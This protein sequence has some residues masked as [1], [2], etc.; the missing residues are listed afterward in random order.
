MVIG[1]ADSECTAYPLGTASCSWEKDEQALA[2]DTLL[3]SLKGM[4]AYAFPPR[5]L[6]TEVLK[7]IHRDQCKVI[8]I[9][10]AWPW[11][12]WFSMILDLLI[13]L[14]VLLT[15]GQTL[16]KQDGVFHPNPSQLQLTA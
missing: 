13:D 14:P 6:L 10:P 9:A 16:L 1:Q 11:R 5:P 7:K 3:I 8:L 12:P 2:W 4:T 15:P